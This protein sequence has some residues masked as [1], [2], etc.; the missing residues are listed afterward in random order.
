MQATTGDSF[1]FLDAEEDSAGV[2]V[3]LATVTDLEGSRP[4]AF[5]SR[6]ALEDLQEH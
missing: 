1:G 5:C 2:C 3:R 4:V 6:S